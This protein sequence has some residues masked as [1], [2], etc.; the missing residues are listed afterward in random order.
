MNQFLAELYGTADN[1]GATDD[2][3]KLAQAEVV[4]QLIEAEGLS[5]D[6]V[7]ADT[8]L[9]VAEELF[10]ADNELAKVAQEAPVE[11]TP[12][13]EKKEEKKEKEEEEEAAEKMAEADFIGRMMAHAMVDELGS[14]EKEAGAKE[15]GLK[16][17]EALKGVGGKAK[18][19]VTDPSRTFKN[20]KATGAVDKAGKRPGNLKAL[21]GTTKK[22]KGQTAAAGGLATLGLGGGA[23]AAGKKKKA[24]A[25]LDA[26][27]EER[28]LSILKEAGYEI[29]EPSQDQAKL[30]EAVD[31][32]AIEMLIEAGFE[33][34]G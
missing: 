12:A 19:W 25:A 15:M 1:I 16:A 33:F 11:E 17:L 13:E 32:R 21:M 18:K 34:E 24:S 2:V 10:G 31:A 27:A 3:E 9:K 26:L 23:Y 5:V 30:A 8:I 4:N 28:A 20:I 14:I 7:D 29:D 22:H 6:D